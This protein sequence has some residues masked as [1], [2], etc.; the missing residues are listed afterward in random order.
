MR[1]RS[2]ATALTVTLVLL[3]GGLIVASPAN[4]APAA[5]P[6]RPAPPA[7]SAA[8]RRYMI[9]ADAEAA[10]RQGDPQATAIAK[11]GTAHPTKSTPGQ[12][13]SAVPQ[14]SGGCAW[15][16]PFCGVVH[17][18]SG[19]YLYLSRDSWAHSYCD[20]H[21]P[22]GYLPDGTDSDGWFG[23]PDTDCFAGTDCWIY[24][25]GS[26]YAPYQWVRIYTDVWVYNVSC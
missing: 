14:G 24:Y 10:A 12:S 17:N 13:G 18:R 15:Y 2:L 19:H 11:G 5:T 25:A 4:A 21:G 9:V 23:W 7:A 6:A 26:W 20:A 1:R 8:G 22:Y 16:D 3:F